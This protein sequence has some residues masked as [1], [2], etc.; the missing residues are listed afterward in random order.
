M[1]IDDWAASRNNGQW[2]GLE[3]GAPLSVHV[4]DAALEAKQAGGTASA[5]PSALAAVTS[6]VPQPSLPRIP[7]PLSVDSDAVTLTHTAPRSAVAPSL[8]AGGEAEDLP[9]AS[10]GEPLFNLAITDIPA[11]KSRTGIYEPL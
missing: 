10:K 7:T 9:A 2:T 4:E 5:P 3:D 8:L 6:S 1:D 11:S